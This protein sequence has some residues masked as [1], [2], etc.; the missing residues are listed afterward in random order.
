M[1]PTPARKSDAGPGMKNV[2]QYHESV[3]KKKTSK[4]GIHRQIRENQRRI[5][6]KRG[7]KK[8]A[9]NK[10]AEKGCNL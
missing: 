4:R 3:N 8:T 2:T 9:G 5:L 1:E 10:N 6:K 7:K